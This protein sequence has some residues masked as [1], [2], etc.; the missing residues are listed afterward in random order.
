MSVSK[1]IF[2][3]DE[4]VFIQSHTGKSIDGSR[5]DYN[6]FHLILHILVDCHKI[7]LCSELMSKYNKK[8]K[9]LENYNRINNQSVRIWRDLLQKKE[10]Q[11]FSE[12]HLNDVPSDLLDDR[13]VIEP[14][15]FLS[16]I[17]VT[18]DEKMKKRV[19]EW[20]EKNSHCLTVELPTGALAYVELSTFLEK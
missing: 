3:L 10:K 2:V 17:L 1:H 20:A 12:S 5:D 13:H 6:S 15:I 11:I 14:A 9:M 4:N 7:G 16:G 19:R 8:S 18:T